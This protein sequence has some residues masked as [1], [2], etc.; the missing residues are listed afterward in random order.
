MRKIGFVLV[1]TVFLTGFCFYPEKVLGVGRE[2]S[3]SQV[4]SLAIAKSESY[5][6]IMGKIE[7][8][9]IKYAAAVKSIKMKQKNMATFR[10]TP[11][12]S[13]KF[14]ENPTLADEYEWKYKPLQILTQKQ[15][16]IH[17]LSDDMC[18]TRE[19]VSLLYVEGYITQ[20]KIDFDEQRLLRERDALKRQ[21]AGRITGKASETDIEKTK[22]SIEKITLELSLLMRSLDTTKEKISDL[23]DLDITVGY[24]FLNPFVEAEIPRGL[25]DLLIDYTLEND[26][27]YYESK[28]DTRLTLTGLNMTQT[29]MQ[30]Q[31]GQELNQVMFYIEQA[32]A[33]KKIDEA[34][35]KRDYE[36]MLESID[37]PW[38]G[39][40]KILFIKINK[41]W[42]KGAIDGSRYVEDDPYVLYSQALEYVDAAKEQAS[43]KKELTRSVKD[44][45]ENIVTA[46]LTYTQ[47]ASEAEKLKEEEKKAVEQNRLGLLDIEDLNGIQEE[48][49][50]QELS[51]LEA[52]SDYTKLLYSFDRL[53]CGG[54]TRY[55]SG[56][57][58]EMNQVERGNRLLT[59]ELSGK[60]YYYLDHKIED[61]IFTLG[62]SVPKEY[63]LELTHFELYADGVRIGE[64]TEIAKELTHLALD[65]NQVEHVQIYLY[66]E[67]ELTA[68]CEIDPEI[69]QD[70]LKLNGGYTLEK[71]D[72]YQV[73]ATYSYRQGEAGLV[74]ITLNPMEREIGYYQITD[75]TGKP[76]AEGEKIA[77]GE[78]FSYLSLLVGQPG[79]LKVNF[80]DRSGSVLYTGIFKEETAC[81]IAE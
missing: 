26:Q 68:V 15:E 46:R 64:K 70:E 30:G 52:L 28:M 37:A 45:Y 17:Q 20:E 79:E 67:E 42:F 1:L 77:I 24:R 40:K 29:L 25:L 55:L 14:P 9:D 13:F 7:V 63:S 43:L 49:I 61:N 76:V 3:L 69:N 38:N 47:A 56:T 32:K 27:S 19:K 80:F 62:I 48:Y 35:F 16:L 51:A 65:L 78:S 57:D 75:F 50:S 73:L 72:S 10:W 18:L 66:T 34:S 23:M 5:Q 60:V 11:L 36:K 41:E 21:Q 4:Q 31:Y 71:S 58:Q 12:L 39:T 33:G 74:T 22:Q 44:G 6:K 81:I 59:E 54:I 53:T 8:Q 2:L